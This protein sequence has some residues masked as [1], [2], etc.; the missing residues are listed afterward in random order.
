MALHPLSVGA[1]RTHIAATLLR[2]SA[3]LHTQGVRVAGLV[4]AWLRAFCPRVGALA[5]RRAVIDPPP[6][7]SLATRPK[8]DLALTLCLTTMAGNPQAPAQVRTMSLA[9]AQLLALAKQGSDGV[10]TWPTSGLHLAAGLAELDAELQAAAAEG[11]HVVELPR[12]RS[13]AVQSGCAFSGGWA[14]GDGDMLRLACHARQLRALPALQ[15]LSVALR[16]SE[17][18]A[19]PCTPHACAAPWLLSGG[20]TRLAFPAYCSR[21]VLPCLPAQFPRLVEFSAGGGKGQAGC[22]LTDEG[23]HALL[24]LPHLRR[25]AVGA[26][27]L[28]RSFAQRR[29]GWEELRVTF[30]VALEQAALLPAGVGRLACRYLKCTLPP[31]PSGLGGDALEEAEC[32]RL[33]LLARAV[34]ALDGME[35]TA[36]GLRLLPYA[37]GGGATPGDAEVAAAALWASHRRAHTSALASALRLLGASQV[38]RSVELLVVDSV[39]HVGADVLPALRAVLAGSARVR[40]GAA[41]PQPL[42]GAAAEQQQ[43]QEPPSLWGGTLTFS[44]CGV[45]AAVWPALLQQVPAASVVVEAP[46]PLP[47]EEQVLALCR[48]AACLGMNVT[49]TVERGPLVA[50]AA[51]AEE[52]E[53][54]EQEV[55][56]LAA[57]LHDGLMRD[58]GARGLAAPWVGLCLEVGREVI[59]VCAPMDALAGE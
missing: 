57:R 25:V 24:Q 20:D 6:L 31:A 45:D 19:E 17:D 43:Q 21:A 33:A 56:V 51:G 15:R 9:V 4:P 55:E 14:D 59:E 30:S 12:L 53:E 46:R 22:T 36:H 52:E 44:S 54:E 35:C 10:A 26:L 7:P 47:T 27:D 8:L 28:E 58:A 49:V 34:Q 23:M 5:L 37:R 48:G 40:S 39:P 29:C 1:P 11:P 16:E 32:L 50:A 3:V 42:D 13:L 2:S 41:A 38:V 18:P